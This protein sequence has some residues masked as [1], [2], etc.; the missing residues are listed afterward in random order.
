VKDALRLQAERS[1]GT[2]VEGWTDRP[3]IEPQFARI[4]ESWCSLQRWGSVDVANVV[5]W[6]DSHFWRDPRWFRSVLVSVFAD[7][8]WEHR[9]LLAAQP[10]PEAE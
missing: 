2:F 9:E 3:T 7:L 4:W 10:Q 5:A 8:M 1:P 6:V